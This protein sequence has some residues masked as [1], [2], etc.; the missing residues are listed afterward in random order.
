VR[1]SCPACL[2]EG[3]ERKTAC[4]AGEPRFGFTITKKLGNAVKRNRIRRRLKAAVL[5]ASEHGRPGFDYVLVARPAAFD[6]PFADLVADV[7]RALDALH[8]P[9]APRADTPNRS[10]NK[11]RKKPAP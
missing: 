4:A 11:T 1:A 10:E 5:A 8:R 7:R 9:R 6:R 2:I 3:R